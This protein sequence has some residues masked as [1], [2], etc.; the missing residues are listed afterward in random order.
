MK[1]VFI[2]IILINSCITDIYKCIYVKWHLKLQKF[3]SY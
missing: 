2:F 1:I 3:S